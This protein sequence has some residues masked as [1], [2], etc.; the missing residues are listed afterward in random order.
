MRSI[1]D[2]II[3]RRNTDSLKYDFAEKRGRPKDI[4]PFWVADMD[5]RTPPFVIDALV[6][7][8]KHGI[9]GYSDGREEYFVHIAIWVVR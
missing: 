5:F 4:L 8:S 3:E 2:E 6:E 9:F 7:R 1:F